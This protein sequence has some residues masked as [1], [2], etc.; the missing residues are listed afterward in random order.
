MRLD[1]YISFLYTSMFYFCVH[2]DIKL[3]LNQ[4]DAE[5]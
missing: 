4:Q 5:R 1:V 2:W 3:E